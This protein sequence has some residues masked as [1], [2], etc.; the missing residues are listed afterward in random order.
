M[1]GWMHVSNTMAYIIGQ[2]L[3]RDQTIHFWQA[4]IDFYK[5]H[6]KVAVST[7]MHDTT[8]LHAIWTSC[9]WTT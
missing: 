1:I 8:T 9:V 6:F 4:S 2:G 5:F 3:I 7:F